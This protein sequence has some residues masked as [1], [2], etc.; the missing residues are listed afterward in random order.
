MAIKNRYEFMYY[1]ACTDSNPN[2][3]PDMGNTPRMD[4]QTMQGYI[5]DVSTKRLIRNYVSMA[6]EGEPGME[7]IVQQSTNMNRQIARAKGSPGWMIV[8]KQKKL[9]MQEE[10]KPVNYFMMCVLLGLL[11][12]QDQMRDR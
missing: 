3:D 1:V 9:F 4:P 10:R 6:R 7:I 11:C 8:L 5:S 12:R 2:G